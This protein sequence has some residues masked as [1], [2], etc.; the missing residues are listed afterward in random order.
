MAQARVA[1][2]SAVSGAAAAPAECREAAP[3]HGSACGQHEWPLMLVAPL[4]WRPAV[5]P[6]GTGSP[7]VGGTCSSCAIGSWGALDATE[8][9]TQCSVPNVTGVTFGTVG[10]VALITT[11]TTS[12]TSTA[13]C[14]R[15]V[16][17]GGTGLTVQTNAASTVQACAT[18]C[19]A[20]N[21]SNG[22]C[23]FITYTLSTAVDPEAG[24]TGIVASSCKLHVVSGSTTALSTCVAC[25]VSTRDC[26]TR[27]HCAAP[28]APGPCSTRCPLPQVPRRLQAVRRQHLLVVAPHC[29]HRC[30]QHRRPRA[31]HQHQHRVGVPGRLQH[32]DSMLGG[33]V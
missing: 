13:D 33:S 2:S 18:A 7:T 14:A 1:S 5:C 11:T 6:A 10:A 19:D 32:P 21:T 31:V 29:Q 25:C 23:A 4:R 27:Q 9:C 8:N 12:S 16:L 3:A 30:G 20:L 24:T 22:T 28:A 26:H 15:G 17:V